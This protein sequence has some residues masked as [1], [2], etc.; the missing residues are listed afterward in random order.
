MPPK[1]YVTA[2]EL[3]DV[4][5]YMRGRLTLDKVGPVTRSTRY[6]LSFLI[7]VT[8][9]LLLHAHSMPAHV[10]TPAALG[11]VLRYMQHGSMLQPFSE[12][13]SCQQFCY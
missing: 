10:P 8:L 12:S 6:F 13:S 4:P 11:S 9:Q 2:N 3:K 1:W 7:Y 5:S